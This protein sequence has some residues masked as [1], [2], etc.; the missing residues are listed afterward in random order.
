MIF[1]IKKSKIIGI[2]SILGNFVTTIVVP[3]LVYLSLLNLSKNNNIDIGSYLLR[4]HRDFL[5]V[6]LLGIIVTILAVVAY[7]QKPYSLQRFFYSSTSLVIYCFHIYFWS[8]IVNLNM[9]FDII[10]IWIDFSNFYLLLVIIPI[11]LIIKKTYNLIVMRKEIRYK[12]IILKTLQANNKVNSIRMLNKQIIK[13]FIMKDDQIQY[14]V[15]NLSKTVKELEIDKWLSRKGKGYRLTRIG[16]LILRNYHEDLIKNI[17]LKEL[18]VWTEK[19][20][21]NY[22][23]N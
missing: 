7:F 6:I 11:L 13:T 16:H 18:E 23:R 20:L 5:T 17:R 22:N 15:N 3:T 10:S 1:M 14:L 12:L 19:D 4:V 8:D 2:V 21:Q 9:S